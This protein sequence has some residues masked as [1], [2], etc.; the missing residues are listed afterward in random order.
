VCD[1]N[2]R[3]EDRTLD[4]NRQLIKFQAV[5]GSFLEMNTLTSEEEPRPGTPP[6]EGNQVRVAGPGDVRLLQRGAADPLNAGPR[7]DAGSAPVR[8]TP[9]SVSR[10]G[11]DR[12]VAPADKGGEDEMKMTYVTFLQRMDANSLT[13]TAN[14]WGGVQVLNFPCDNPTEEIDLDA[15]LSRE[16]PPNWMYLRCDRLQVFDKQVDGRSNQQ[17]L[18]FGR[19]RVIGKDY[20]AESDK[21]TFEEAKD[22]VIFYGDKNN[23]A[24]LT[25]QLGRGTERRTLS[26]LKIYYI[27]R[28]GEAYVEGADRINR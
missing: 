18:A 6:K 28:T 12:R 25:Q 4:R 3:V 2:V 20:S 15:I 9:V 17:M 1:Q 7:A 13:N 27:R 14:F 8:G 10:T 26:G 11:P 22:Q 19:V 23:P 24:T 5:S 16:L 21:M